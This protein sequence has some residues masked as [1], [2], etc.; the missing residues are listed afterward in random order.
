MQDRVL[1]AMIDQWTKAPSILRAVAMGV[2]SL[3]KLEAEGAARCVDMLWNSWFLML[4]AVCDSIV[5][6]MHLR[7]THRFDSRF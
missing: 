3:A 5:L 2:H 6:Q 7:G 4:E 1:E